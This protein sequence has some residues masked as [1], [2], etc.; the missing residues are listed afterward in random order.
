MT[1]WRLFSDYLCHPAIGTSLAL[2]DLVD[3]SILEWLGD[4]TSQLCIPR[5][6]VQ[7]H[8][9]AEGHCLFNI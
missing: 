6:S 8:V 7:I 3:G 1:T 5:V 2:A 4:A 9:L